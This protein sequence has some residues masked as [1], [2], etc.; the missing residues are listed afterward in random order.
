MGCWCMQPLSVKPQAESTLFNIKRDG[1][2]DI[3]SVS[4]KK[5][6]VFCAEKN[7]QAEGAERFLGEIPRLRPIHSHRRQLQ[8]VNCPKL[9]FLRLSRTDPQKSPDI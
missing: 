6:T 7:S 1:N 9:Q 4:C 3:L 5:R 8:T 2:L